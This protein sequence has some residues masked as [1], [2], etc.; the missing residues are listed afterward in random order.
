MHEHISTAIMIFGSMAVL[1]IA[2]FMAVI[3]SNKAE[4]EEHEEDN[5]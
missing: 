2:G 5:A 4:A 1:P 3:A